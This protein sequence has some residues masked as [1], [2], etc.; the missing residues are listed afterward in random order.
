M[1]RQYSG[2]IPDV[3][4]SVDPTNRTDI[5]RI[6]DRGKVSAFC[7]IFLMLS[8]VLETVLQLWSEMCFGIS[9]LEMCV[10][11]VQLVKVSEWYR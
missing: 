8:E 11:S 10:N 3:L 2:I 4:R 9:Y 6:I 5:L 1:L 7:D